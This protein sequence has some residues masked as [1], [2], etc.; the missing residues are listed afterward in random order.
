M[1]NVVYSVWKQILLYIFFTVNH[2]L[3]R[4]T[5]LVNNRY[6]KVII[7]SYSFVHF[8]SIS[9][10]PYPMCG[11]ANFHLVPLPARSSAACLNQGVTVNYDI[12]SRDRWKLE[13]SPFS[14]RT[15]PRPLEEIEVREKDCAEYVWV[16]DY[17]QPKK[18]RKFPMQPFKTV[19]RSFIYFFN[20]YGH[21]SEQK[22]Q[23]F[24][25]GSEKVQFFWVRNIA[26][27]YGKFWAF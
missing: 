14:C 9:L 16:R 15:P 7:I 8:C 26:E 6:W 20:E 10:S 19:L 5:V 2:L 13:T 25:S 12:L 4:W 22:T 27:K 24:K 21:L 11:P 18:L 3:L 1:E 17:K 23:E